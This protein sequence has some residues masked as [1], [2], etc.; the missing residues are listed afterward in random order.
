[1]ITS[2]HGKETSVSVWLSEPGLNDD[3]MMAIDFHD[4]FEAEKCYRDPVGYGGKH[5]LPAFVAECLRPGRW[6]EIDGPRE[7]YASRRLSSELVVDRDDG[8][9]DWHREQAM[10][11]GMGLGIDA[12]N[13]AMGYGDN[14][15]DYDEEF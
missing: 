1:M 6:I 8:D 9:D 12:Y 2:D 5:D 15:N 3:C 13:D 10:Q 11:L 4:A 7:R 14:D